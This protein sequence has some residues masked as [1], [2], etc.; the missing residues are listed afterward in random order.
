MMNHLIV[1]NKS[2]SLVHHLFIYNLFIFNTPVLLR[3]G[4]GIS[5]EL[6]CDWSQSQSQ[7]DSGYAGSG[8]LEQQQQ[9]RVH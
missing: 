9:R 8:K 6:S 1:S 4:G 7:L 3:G 2:L 5:K